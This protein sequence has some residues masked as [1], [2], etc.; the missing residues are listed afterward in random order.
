MTWPEGE[1]FGL[2]MPFIVCSDQGGPYDAAAFVAGAT[3]QAID[4]ELERDKP[5]I[6]SHYVDPALVA[7]LDLSA[8]RHGYRLEAAPWDEHPDEWTLVTFH[9]QAS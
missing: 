6:T 2:V 8:M 5:I 4:S 7:Q 1:N 9:R 3:W